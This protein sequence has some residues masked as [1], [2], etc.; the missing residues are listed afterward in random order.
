MKRKFKQTVSLV[1]LAVLVLTLTA[2][3]SCVAGT[4]SSF[5]NSWGTSSM[6]TE[7]GDYS[8]EFNALNDAFVDMQDLL[9]ELEAAI[10]AAKDATISCGDITLEIIEAM[11]EDD[12]DAALLLIPEG[13]EIL[14]LAGPVYDRLLD[15][16]EAVEIQME[17]INAITAILDNAGQDTSDFNTGNAADLVADGKT[18]ASDLLT[19]M[20]TLVDIL[21][22]ARSFFGIMG[23]ADTIVSENDSTYGDGNDILFVAWG[24]DARYVRH[25]QAI[26]VI[27]LYVSV[28][29]NNLRY[30]WYANTNNSN[31]GGTPISGATNR[32]YKPLTQDLGITYYYCVASAPD[33]S[34]VSSPPI[35]VQVFASQAELNLSITRQPESNM[36]MQGDTV[37]EEDSLFIEATGENVGY[38]WY[39]GSST[40]PN[41]TLIPDATQNR[42]APP[43]DQ[44]GEFY[45]FCKVSGAPGQ[46]PL[47]SYTIKVQVLPYLAITSQPQDA[48]YTQ[49]AT[50]AP[51]TTS[52]EGENLGYQWYID[53]GIPTVANTPIEGATAASYTPPTN[54]LGTVRYFCEVSSIVNNQRN[55][56]TTQAATVTVVAPTPTL[57][58]SS[59]TVVESTQVTYTYNLGVAQAGVNVQFAFPENIASFVNGGLERVSTYSGTTDAAGVITFQVVVKGLDSSSI[60]Y[61]VTATNPSG[62]ATTATITI[63]KNSP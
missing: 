25:T 31:T 12:E 8:D 9:E 30:Q 58:A 34:S 36:Y 47:T 35:S 57:T 24:N 61:P 52:A 1:C 2:G 43:T 4:D 33:G 22:D 60:S 51:L 55:A 23:L 26:D 62:V 21:E 39:A 56:L 5:V 54:T 45:Y 19:A 50:A 37:S 41:A 38:Q 28:A 10:A 49:N 40:D 46:H 14:E 18:T 53:S 17:E 29:G 6:S 20:T 27:D 3:S 32:T 16:I 13:E 59:A 11:T 44:V 63:T 7:Y 42:F 48:Q 15:A